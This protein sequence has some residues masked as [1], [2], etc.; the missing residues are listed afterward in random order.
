MKYYIPVPIL[1]QESPT[2]EITPEA[3]TTNI[4]E[5]KPINMQHPVKVIGNIPKNTAPYISDYLVTPYPI[6]SE[7]IKNIILELNLDHVQLEP[8]TIYINDLSHNGYYLLNSNNFIDAIDEKNSEIERRSTGAI[9]DIEKL[10]LND[11]LLSQLNP[12]E[13]SIFRIPQKP[14]IYIFCA[15]LVEAINNTCPSGVTFIE[16]EKWYSTIMFDI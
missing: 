5:G 9:L 16:A 7:K 4:A 14:S 13:R 2:F 6:V 15:T 11:E 8:A 12:N 1:K 3:I 10:S